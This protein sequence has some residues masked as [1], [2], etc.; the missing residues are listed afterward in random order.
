MEEPVVKRYGDKPG[1]YEEYP[2]VKPKANRPKV[3]KYAA[4][5]DPLKKSP[6]FDVIEGIMRKRV[7]VID[8][9]MGTAVQKYKLSEDDFRG[10]RYTDHTHDLKGNNDVLVLTKPEVISEIHEAYLAAGADIIE[11]NT[12]SLSLIHI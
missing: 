11:T 7:M 4:Y 8:G 2:A 1:Y 12:F 10:S 9:A 5:E 3:P 6:A